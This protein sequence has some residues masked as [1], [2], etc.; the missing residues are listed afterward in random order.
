LNCEK[1]VGFAIKEL[2]NIIRRNIIDKDNEECGQI[3]LMQGWILGFLHNN[4]DKD[5]YQRD[6]EKQ[7]EIRRSTATNILNLME[8]NGY[9]KREKTE[10][11]ARLKKICLTQKARQYN[12]N[13]VKR[14]ENTEKLMTK[15]IS[16]EEIKTFFEVVEK[17]KSNLKGE[18]V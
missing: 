4:C 17:I 1:H 14:I 7:F 11:D 5:I 13:L 8:K 9:I 6:I 3:P 18:C 15:N 10:F 2:A 16:E 12:D